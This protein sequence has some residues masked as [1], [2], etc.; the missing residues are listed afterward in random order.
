MQMQFN[1]ADHEETALRFIHFFFLA[2]LQ[3]RK[4]F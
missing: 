3:A 2:V 1:A 4:E